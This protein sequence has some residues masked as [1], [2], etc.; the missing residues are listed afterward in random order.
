MSN[1]HLLK[2]QIGR[3]ERHSEPLR[4]ILNGLVMRFSAHSEQPPMPTDEVRNAL[5]EAVDHFCGMHEFALHV[6]ELH[7]RAFSAL[8]RRQ[9]DELGTTLSTQRAPEVTV[10]PDCYFVLDGDGAAIHAQ[11]HVTLDAAESEAAEEGDRRPFAPLPIILRC[12]LPK[13]GSTPEIASENA[14]APEPTDDDVDHA[15]AAMRHKFGSE[16]MV[17]EEDAV[18]E[19]L[20]ADRQR[21]TAPTGQGAKE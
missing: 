15:V 4:K 8:A 13:G 17:S 11:P 6:I 12:Y 20:R 14:G 16:A 9:A 19:A 5:S 2:A 10:A 3:L 7:E 1:Q 18:R 21:R